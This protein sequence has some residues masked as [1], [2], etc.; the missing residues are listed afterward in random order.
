M[1]DKTVKDFVCYKIYFNKTI[2]VKL[3]EKCLLK[4]VHKIFPTGTRDT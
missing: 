1:D 3:Y 2:K 4:N